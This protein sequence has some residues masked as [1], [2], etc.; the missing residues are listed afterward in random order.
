MKTLVMAV[1]MF[2]FVGCGNTATNYD[3]SV[4]EHDFQDYRGDGGGEEGKEKAYGCD[5]LFAKGAWVSCYLQ[6]FG[7]NTDSCQCQLIWND[8][9]CVP[10]CLDANGKNKFKDIEITAMEM[11]SYVCKPSYNPAEGMEGEWADGC[12]PPFPEKT[13]VICSNPF[14]GQIGPCQLEWDKQTCRASCF[15]FKHGFDNATVENI[16]A[17]CAQI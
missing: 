15:D 3:I 5:S 12:C 7:I 4:G 17:N 9:T 1:A 10:L 14:V 16:A 6:D 8:E 2:W 13:W 11:V